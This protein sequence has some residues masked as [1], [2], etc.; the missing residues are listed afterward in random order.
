MESGSDAAVGGCCTCVLSGRSGYNADNYI[1]S[2]QSVIV[3]TRTTKISKQYPTSSV[4]HDYFH[5]LP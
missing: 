1:S 4:I 2:A 5:T 3:A